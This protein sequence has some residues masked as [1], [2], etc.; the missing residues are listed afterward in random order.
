MVT[1]SDKKQELKL[2]TNCFSGIYLALH[3]THFGLVFLLRKRS[4]LGRCH[5]SLSHLLHCSITGNTFV[6][7]VW[8]V[9]SNSL[10]LTPMTDSF[11]KKKLSRNTGLWITDPVAHYYS[12]LHYIML[13]GRL[14]QHFI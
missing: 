2:T 4:L 6:V 5:A 8:A 14:L 13:F 11:P 12:Q 1:F 10:H 9:P 3:C 7:L